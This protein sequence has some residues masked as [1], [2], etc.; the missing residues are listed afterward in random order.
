VDDNALTGALRAAVRGDVAADAGTR[1]LY[2][3]DASNYRV[4][5]RAIVLP[6]TVEDVAAVIGVCREFR[7]P[8]TARGA[9]TSIAGNAIG[10]GVILDF[11]RHLDAVLELDPVARLAR[12]QPGVVLDTL[13][14]AAAR[15]GLRFGPDPSS[16]SRCTLGGMIGNNACGTHSV[17]WGTTAQ[18]VEELVVALPDGSRLVAGDGTL[19]AAVAD[20]ERD[21]RALIRTELP[22]WPRRG[23]GYALQHLLPE[24]G[25]RLA[26]ALVGT[27]GT[28]AVLL[29]ATVR[30]IAP[31]AAVALLVL[32]FPSLAEAA[33]AAPGL[34]RHRPLTVEG[35]DTALVAASALGTRRRP[36]LPAGAAWL[37]VEFGGDVL[38]GAVASARAVA[39]ELGRP[40]L[41]VADPAHRA[42]LWRIR[43]AGAGLATRLPDG[44]QAWPGWEDAT[45]PPPRLG[46]YLRD[47]A[48]LLAEHGRRG[49][50][51]GHFGEG[52]VH[53][54]IDADVVSTPGRRDF[55]RLLEQAADLVVLH[56]GSLCGEHGD[57]RARGELL[58]RMYPP[59]VLRLFAQFKAVFDPD[60]LLNPGV[61]VDPRPLDADLRPGRERP[62]PVSLA[63]GRDGGSL[64]AATR[65][66]VG[67]GACRQLGGTGVMCPSFQVTRD[68]K[69]STRGRAHLLAEMLAGDLLT[70]GWRSPEV[71]EALDLCLACKACA[72]E[73]PVNVDMA[74]YK[75]EFLHQRYRWRLRPRWH[76]ALGGFPL[77]ARIGSSAPAVANWVAPFFAGVGGISTARPLPRFAR[78][79]PPTV[80]GRGSRGAVLLWPD[81]FTRSFD[82]QVVHAA[83]RVLAAAGFAVRLPRGTVCCGLTWFTT[84]QFGTARLVLRRS[85]RLLRVAVSA[86]VPVVG[87]EPSCVAMLRSDLVELLPDHPA[88][89]ALAQRGRTLAEVLRERAPDW[90]PPERPDDA[91]QQVHCHQ[92]AVLGHEADDALLGLAGIRVRRAS[93]CCGLAG[94]FGYQRGHEELSAALAQRSLV[95]AIRAMPGALVLA[96]GFSCR[97]QIAQ[98][99]GRRALHLAEL[100]DR[101][102]RRG[103]PL[104][105][106]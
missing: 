3:T 31:P 98:T 58:G 22:D 91:V 57:G 23:S 55:R 64:V 27:E 105:E 88:A 86:G 80:G 61:L 9:G 85:L 17:A 50:V 28:C 46:G 77:A 4:L 62:V 93:G 92:H 65:R 24:H 71:D 54:R 100:L 76:Y 20:L 41:V 75:A 56:D 67:I 7:V 36:E 84:G 95:P 15:H 35:L 82:P 2:T 69:H 30:L 63:L 26:R 74:T 44:S 106:R 6:R 59:A 19:P 87:L 21:N 89:A 49:A 94:S 102:I 90:Q 45:V 79:R 51:Y 60:G 73:C 12:V 103:Q 39:L 10:P 14:A 18:A 99:T 97:Q 48:A 101:G 70:G 104:V 47:F 40:H 5:P 52:C 38:D 33:D 83:A 34:L 68:E 1:A 42:A 66:C 32:G 29:E 43:E 37:L 13:Q 25:S 8:L 78:Y 53:V 16:H 96:D 81:C 72:S 11:S